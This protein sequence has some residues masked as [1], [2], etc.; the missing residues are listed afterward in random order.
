[1]RQRGTDRFVQKRAEIILR[2]EE[3]RR[4]RDNRLE[5]RW[6]QMF[7]EALR[8]QEEGSKDP[9]HTRLQTRRRGYCVNGQVQMQRRRGS[10]GGYQ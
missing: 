6:S 4:V 10:H 8:Q 3:L 9:E 7:T 5:L 1:M 2:G